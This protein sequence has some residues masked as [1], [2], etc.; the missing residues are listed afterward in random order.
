[1]LKVQVKI[2]TRTEEGWKN[3]MEKFTRS[4]N[5]ILIILSECSAMRNIT[6]NS[7]SKIL[8]RV[9]LWFGRYEDLLGGV[10]YI[11]AN[12]RSKARRRA[13]WRIRTKKR[14]GM[15]SRKLEYC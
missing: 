15:L 6:A 14:T 4:T 9:R 2:G 3:E 1:M 12:K 8:R 13:K 5:R 7:M 11:R 10:G